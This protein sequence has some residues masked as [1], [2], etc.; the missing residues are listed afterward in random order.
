MVL[1]LEGK[2]KY[3]EIYSVKYPSKTIIFCSPIA[4]FT[5]QR[6]IIAVNL[7]KKMPET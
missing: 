6:E 2:R 4:Y 5:G 7:K 1:A 3:G